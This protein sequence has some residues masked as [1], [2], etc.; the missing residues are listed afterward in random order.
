[1]LALITG[2]T[3]GLGLAIAEALARAGH[4]LALIYRSDFE[5]AAAAQKYLSEWAPVAT[6]AA[7]IANFAQVAQT[8]A[9][10]RAAQGPVSVLINNA[11]RS[12]R[13]PQKVHQID[14]AAWQ[15]DLSTNLSGA[16]AVTQAVLPDMVAQKYGRIVFIG[17]LAGRGEMG[18]AAYATAKSA[19]AGLAGTLAQEYA[20]D[21]ITSNVVAPGFL[22]TGAFLRLPL[23]TQERALKRVPSRRAGTPAEVAATVAH[24]ASKSAAY[25]NGQVIAVDGGAR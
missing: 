8:V 25:I 16:F 2:G 7:D 23:E 6:Y 15:E 21:G 3:R 9:Q 22:A 12:G 17:S 18:R 24:L 10:L 11:F 4:P 14:P 1:M 13:P 20:K 19:F 5:A